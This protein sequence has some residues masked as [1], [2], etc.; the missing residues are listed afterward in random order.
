MTIV[1][2]GVSNIVKGDRSLRNT[3]RFCGS[4]Y[5]ICSKVVIITCVATVIPSHWEVV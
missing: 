1:A 2:L 4:F 5:T 3:S